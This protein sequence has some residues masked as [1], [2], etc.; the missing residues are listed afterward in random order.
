MISDDDIDDVPLEEE[1][2]LS[3]DEQLDETPRKGV[4]IKSLIVGMILAAL[5]GAVGG[6]FLGP[7][8]TPASPVVQT[9]LSGVNGSLD[10][11]ARDNKAFK[12]Q[13]LKLQKQA[14]P[15]P[16]DLSPLLTRIE[17]LE[18]AGENAA[19]PVIDEALIARLEALQGE[20]S[21]ALD[22]S[23]ITQR[24]TALESAAPEQ[25]NQAA[26]QDLYER[27]AEL[28]LKID[29][30]LANGI[31]ADVI[32]DAPAQ[33][34][35]F[36]L[37]A[38][39]EADI[40]A[41]LAGMNKSESWTKRTLNKHISVRSEDDPENLIEGIKL[42]LEKNDLEAAASKFDRLPSQLRSAGQAWRA[43]LTP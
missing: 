31:K 22:L 7:R 13:I 41:A 5:G 9:D 1:D 39:P 29:D 27:Q 10:A 16:A 40:R 33:A 3:A 14:A 36:A 28:S 30:A 15:A 6:T 4:G 23:D 12:A 35:S 11:L 43:A 26:L 2:G 8:L 17:A 20:G 42:D 24:L 32:I 38:F 34:A 37:P 21:T 19:A 18:Q 25:D